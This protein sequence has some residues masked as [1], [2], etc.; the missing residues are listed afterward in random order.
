MSLFEIFFSRF[1]VFVFAFPEPQ[2][3]YIHFVL[4]S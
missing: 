3:K 4:S 1:R 2:V